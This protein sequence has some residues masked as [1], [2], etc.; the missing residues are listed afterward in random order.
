MED[1]T[2]RIDQ[3]VEERKAEMI[4]E[5]QR[6]LEELL[7]AHDDLVRLSLFLLY[8]LILISWIRCENCFISKNSLLWCLMILRKQSKT[9]PK[10]SSKYARFFF[11]LPICSKYFVVQ[12][13]V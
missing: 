6:K 11:I 9:S 7:D 3:K 2:H 5:R 10:C 1:D 13:L 8:L 4:A 12:I